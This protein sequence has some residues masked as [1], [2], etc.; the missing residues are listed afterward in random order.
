MTKRASLHFRI[1]IPL[2]V[3]FIV[4]WGLGLAL[5]IRSTGSAKPSSVAWLTCQG[6]LG[7]V[8][9]T[10]IGF[11]VVRRH[12]IV[13]IERMM[14]S[15]DPAEEAAVREV[16][17]LARGADPLDDLARALDAAL[18]QRS[19]GEARARHRIEE[20]QCRYQAF[21]EH[22]GISETGVDGRITYVNPRFCELSGYARE[23]L[24]GM[25]PR[26]L[27]SG[28]HGGEFWREVFSELESEGVWRGEV[29]NRRPNGEEYWISTTKLAVRGPTGVVTRYVAISNDITDRVRA[30]EEAERA[31]GLLEVFVEHAPA[32]V[33]M[34][35]REMR[36]LACSRKWVTDY[37]LEGVELLGRSHYEVFPEIPEAWRA[38]HERCLGGSVERC[39]E[40]PFVRRSGQVQ[41]LR[42]ET[43]PWPAPDGTIGGLVMCT[44]DITGARRQADELERARAQAEGAARAK[45]DFLAVMSHELRTPMNGVLG[46]ANLL[47]D[48]PL[49]AEQRGY[50]QTIRQSGDALL[51]LLNDLLDF[52]KAE[53]GRMVFE[54]SVT[55]SRLAAEDVVE[56]LVPRACEAGIEVVLMAD[57]EPPLV[58][59]DPARLRQVLTNLLGNAIKFT[60]K[61]EICLRIEPVATGREGGFVRFSVTDTGIGISADVLPELFTRFRQA[62]AS[63]SRRYGGTGLGLAIS[64]QLVEA[65]GG[66]IGVTSQPGL[67]STFWFTLRGAEPG[68]D[69]STADG[70]EPL[71]RLAGGLRIL[72]VVD[73]DR[74]AELVERLLK[75]AGVRH[76]VR[77]PG[78]G[79]GAGLEWLDSVE[80]ADW[81]VVILDLMVPP[82]GLEKHLARWREDRE[83]STPPSLLVFECPNRRGG[84]GL[85]AATRED[86]LW[87]P[88]VRAR[89]FLTKLAELGTPLPSPG[90]ACPSGGGIAESGST[91]VGSAHRRVLVVEDN[92]VNQLITRSLVERFGHRVDVAGNGLE[93]VEMI[94][95]I[96]YDLVLMDCQMPEMDG[97]EAT[98]AIRR[99]EE[100][101]GRGR[102]IPV[103][104]VTASP[105]P[106][107][108]E[109]CRECG[110]DG[111]LRKPLREAALGAELSRFLRDG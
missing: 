84:Q 15:L 34:F 105:I 2:L 67:G 76:D 95:Q 101:H 70:M 54:P 38:V 39:D 12:V 50:V 7:L 110:M 97:F 91:G 17:S 29:C 109:R 60:Q 30:S 108:E 19:A 6:V 11:W 40:D 106:E 59:A 46:F 51:G 9:L 103:I 68:V 47:A 44:V 88:L 99:W 8:T 10:G 93:A 63:I 72:A 96:E 41:W 102:R 58:L 37:G 3:A 77:R 28:R 53:S 14:R 92:G 5:L 16:S 69:A 33:A 75:E 94:L 48:T 45:A 98:R 86:V 32:A 26:L 24:L 79:D 35:D 90:K 104:A 87:R 31:Q 80:R 56:L 49:D 78:R 36:Y 66:Q 65:M 43:R 107:V 55:S 52:S 25:D 111:L 100:G 57:A 61:G 62:D 20:L 21:D 27:K 85:S 42:W 22:S 71:P 13:P 82:Q 74:P 73:R 1:L 4:I 83:G 81:D 18:E 23:Q 64:K 89:R